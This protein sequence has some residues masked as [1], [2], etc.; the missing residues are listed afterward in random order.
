MCYSFDASLNAWL[1]SFICSIYML[2]HPAFYGFWI[3]IFILTFTQIQIAESIIWASP[4]KNSYMTRMIGYLL[5]LQP[6]INSYMGYL[7]TKTTALFYMA[8][9]FG[10][11]MIF[12]HVTAAA[13]TF[14]STVGPTGSLQWNRFNPD[15]EEVGIFGNKIFNLAYLIGL[16]VPFLYM[17]STAKYIP[18]IVGLPTLLWSRWYSPTEYGSKWCYSAVSMSVITLM[19]PTFFP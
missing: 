10:F 16:F 15:G 17:D 18:F 19:W 11:V 6:L 3:P 4:D 1:V 12:Y 13:D 7:D 8:I 2:A 5:W 9:F 14:E